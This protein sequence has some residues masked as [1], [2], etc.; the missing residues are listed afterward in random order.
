[1]TYDEAAAGI[2]TGGGHAL[3]FL[4]KGKIQGGQKVLIY[5]TSG[6]VGSYAIQLAKYFGAEVTGVRSTKNLDLVIFHCLVIQ[7]SDQLRSIITKPLIL[8]QQFDLIYAIKPRRLHLII[9]IKI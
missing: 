6:S 5:G 3:R 7:K 8:I 2:P 9:V 1:M 4:R